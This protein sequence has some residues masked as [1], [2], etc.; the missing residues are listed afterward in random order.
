MA[1]V[2]GYWNLRGA[3]EP[4]ILTLKQAKASYKLRVYKLGDAPDF[5]KSDWLNEKHNLGLPYPNLPYYID[6]D[7]KITQTLAILHYLARKHDLGPRNDSESIR[8]DIFEQGAFEITHSL[9]TAWYV[10]S[11][12]EF[13]DRRPGLDSYLVEKLNHTGNAFGSNKFILGDRV[14]YVDFL[15]YSTLDYIRQYK[16]SLLDPHANLRSYLDRIEALPEINKYLKSNSFSRFPITDAT[17]KWGNDTI[18]K[19]Y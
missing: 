7:L 15:L 18:Q 10:E 3:V 11:D 12:Q 6:G 16:P 19:P 17:A 13:E 5:D 4:I 2:I 14:T 1:P 8:S 9:W